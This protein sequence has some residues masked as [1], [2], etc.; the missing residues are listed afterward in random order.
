ML[1]VSNLVAM[2]LTGVL[3]RDMHSILSSPIRVGIMIII[4]AGLWYLSRRLEKRFIK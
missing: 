2:A 4:L 3:G 1:A